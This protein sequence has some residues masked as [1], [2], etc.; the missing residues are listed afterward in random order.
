MKK[1]FRTS[2]ALLMAATLAGCGSTATPEATT[3]AATTAAATTAAATETAENAGITGEFSG[4]GKGF[5]GDVTVTLNLKDS[6]LESAEIVGD[7]ETPNVGG[8]AIEK[9][10]AEM[11]EHH[12]VNVDSVSGAT[13][14]SK[15]IEEAL[16]AALAA[17]GMSKS[18]FP[19]IEKAEA[20]TIEKETDLLIIGGGG[21]GLTCGN[22]ALNS[23]L[24]NVTILEKMSYTGGATSNAGGI[25]AGLSKLQEE[26][27]LTGDSVQLIHDD[28]MASGEG[29]NE[30]L[31]WIMAENQG[32][33]LDWLRD[34]E[35]VP[36]NDRYGS[37][38]PE[39]TVQRFFVCDGG[40]SN[41]MEILTDNFTKK[42]GDLELET[43]AEELITDD[44]GKVIGVVATDADG[45]TINWKADAVV[46]ATGGYGANAEMISE[47]KGD[48]Q[49]AVF[50]GVKSSMGDGQKMGEKVGAKM[51]NMGY[52]KMY[53][54]GISKGEDTIDGYATPMPTLTTVNTTGAFF[55]NKDSKRFVDETL[56]FA[57]IKNATTKQPDEIMYIVMDQTGYDTWS[58]MVSTNTSAVGNI[59][60]EQQEEFFNSD[61]DHPTFARGT[62]KEAAEKAGLDPEALEAE[63]KKWNE[64]VESGKDAEF[65]RK[66]LTKFDENST[67]YI[68]EQRLRFATTLG[69]FDITKNFE[70]QKEDGTVIPGLYAIGEVTAGCNGTEA[71]PGSMAA[72]AVTSGYTCGQYL[73]EMLGK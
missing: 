20:K 15:G 29:H 33:T 73:G 26:V 56:A 40:M 37:D 23:G 16:A 18:D 69:G 41:A 58:E 6:V 48:L 9:I 4:T 7:K 62:L 51:L 5:E 60:M 12:T 43:K 17:A 52:A 66:A 44:E 25:D 30:D 13:Y 36:F 68:I 22:A 11:N 63:L 72:W 53:P 38:F 32:K 39:H 50:Y 71:I 31:V 59:S 28:I 47:K 3:A 21:A 70:A 42:G 54:N 57:D 45:N 27:G 35:K 67:V 61:S 14:T 8:K 65:G 34:T 2:A 49:Y 55:V 64:T 24:K 10:M 46:I 19:E 1:V